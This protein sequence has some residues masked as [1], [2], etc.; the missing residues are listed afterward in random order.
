[1]IF[2][3]IKIFILIFFSLFINMNSF[4][5][6]IFTKNDVE[7]FVQKALEYINK[8]GKVAA[9]KE[10][11]NPNGDFKKGSHGELYIFAYDFNGNVLAHGDK[12][13]LV[14]YNLFHLK[15]PEGNYPIQK[16]I[17]AVHSKDHWVKYIWINP[18]DKKIEKKMGYC[19]KVDETW[20]IG[21]GLY[22]TEETNK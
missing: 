8:N 17:N 5:K 19:L 14:G 21:S 6:E 15:D 9:L 12:P 2:Y 1:M 20:W 22:V 18:A 3:K 16:L 4:S 7:L 11:T 13:K 10:F